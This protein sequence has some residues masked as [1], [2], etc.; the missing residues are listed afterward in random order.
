LIYLFQK[1]KLFRP[2]LNL[3][4]AG[5]ITTSGEEQQVH[6]AS[7]MSCFF[8]DSNTKNKMEIFTFVRNEMMHKIVNVEI[9]LDKGGGGCAKA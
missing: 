6:F 9:S 1:H 8:E 2:L 5:C 4:K 7:A 3:H